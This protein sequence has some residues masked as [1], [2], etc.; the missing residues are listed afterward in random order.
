VK[1]IL[2]THAFFGGLASLT[3]CHTFKEAEKMGVGNEIRK[4][5]KN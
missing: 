3:D 4:N 2:D 5:D 1:L